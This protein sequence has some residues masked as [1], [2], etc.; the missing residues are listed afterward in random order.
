MCLSMKDSKMNGEELAEFWKINGKNAEQ[1]R[2]WCRD[3]I[4]ETTSILSQG[5]PNRNI[6]TLHSKVI[7]YYY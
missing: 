3:G 6:E 1:H 2:V 7:I 5:S 4:N